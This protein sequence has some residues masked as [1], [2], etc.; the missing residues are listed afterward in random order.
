M[1]NKR[2]WVDFDGESFSIDAALIA[3][4]LGMGS[5]KVQALMRA[6]KITSVCERGIEQDAGR[7]RL[8]FRHANQMLRFVVDERGEILQR[9]LEPAQAA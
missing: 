9:I 2:E 5:Q 4:A 8:S 6:R 3:D 7:Y 1:D